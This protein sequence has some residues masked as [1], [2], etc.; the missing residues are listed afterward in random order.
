MTRLSRLAVAQACVAVVVLTSI[1]FFVAIVQAAHAN[2][3]LEQQLLAKRTEVAEVRAAVQT[4]NDQVAYERTSTFVE[5]AAREQLNLA[6]QGDHPI[7]VQGVPMPSAHPSK[8]PLTTIPGK[9]G[10]AVAK[11]AAPSSVTPSE[12]VPNWLL[13]VRYWTSP[14]E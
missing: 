5:Q 13:W 7:Q 4:L 10:P 8:A 11:P 14:A 6:R 9:P 1:W 3:R 2:Q 12:P